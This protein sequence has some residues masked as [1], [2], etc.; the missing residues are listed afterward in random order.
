MANAKAKSVT[1]KISSTREDS[2]STSGSCRR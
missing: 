1:V 2:V